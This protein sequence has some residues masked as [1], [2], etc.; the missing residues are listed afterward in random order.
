[1]RTIELVLAIV[2]LVF[3][4]LQYND[5]DGLYW[6]AVYA[7]AAAWC[8]LAVRRPGLIAGSTLLRAGLAVSVVAFLVGFVHLA[9]AIDANWIHVEEAREALGYLIC[10]LA[11][12]T[13][14]LGDRRAVAGGAGEPA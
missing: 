9:P 10:A 14:W 7:L 8:G 12:A 4:V 1:M 11:T 3:A 5:P 13:A 6:F 2:L